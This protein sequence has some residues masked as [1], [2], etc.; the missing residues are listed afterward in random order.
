VLLCAIF[1]FSVALVVRK[2]DPRFHHRGTENTKIAQRN[3]LKTFRP[4]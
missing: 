4:Y 1:V 2:D 3:P